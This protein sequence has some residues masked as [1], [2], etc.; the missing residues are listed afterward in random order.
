MKRR[1]ADAT[2]CVHAGE[3]RHGES[4]ALATP[5][6]QT[7]V[8]VVPGLAE[9]RRYAEGNRNIYLYARYGTPTVKAAEDKIAALEGAEDAVITSSGMSAILVAALACCQAGDEIVSMLDIYGGTVKL[10]EDVLGRCG[11]KTRFI[12]YRDLGKAAR[13][14]SRKTRMLFLETPTNPTLRCADIAALSAIAHRYKASVVVDNTFATP[15]LQKPL[16]LGADVVMHSATKYLGGHSDLTAGALAGS[17]K[18]M[19]RARELMIL[20]GG[21]L[22]PGCAYLLLR[23]LKTLELRVERACHNAAAVAAALQRHPKVSQVYYPGLPSHADHELASR[24]MKDY[25]MMVSCEL[26]GGE[27]AVDHFVKRLKLWYLATSLGGVESILSYPALS[28][29]IGL[30][31]KRLNLLGVTASTVRLSV[32]V[33]DHA[34]LIADLESALG[35]VD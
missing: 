9:L 3:D 26:R 15:I 6:T 34:D 28:S 25:G 11:I 32:G 16:V 27:A 23:G 31:A 14:L 19:D 30:S 29:H 22:D 20:T 5:I 33:E 4:A 8:F 1:T 7:S 35:R 21:C 17:K 12:P 13:F 18:L 2:R 10:F 24:Q